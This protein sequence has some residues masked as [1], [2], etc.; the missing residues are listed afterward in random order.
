[1]KAITTTKCVEAVPHLETALLNHFEPL[2]R[3]VCT[4]PGPPRNRG[5]RKIVDELAVIIGGT[6][7]P[8]CAS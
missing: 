2:K 8:L 3:Q 5:R 6:N 4:V 1:M 7:K